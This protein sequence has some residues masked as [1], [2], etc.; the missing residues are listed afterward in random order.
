MKKKFLK[1]NV[2]K[3]NEGLTLIELLLYLS[4]VIIIVL[5][6]SSFFIVVQK[7]KV[8]NEAISTVEDQGKFAMG[9]VSEAIHRAVRVVEP[10]LGDLT[11]SLILSMS[12]P[13]KD[14]T[15]FSVDNDGILNMTEGSNSPIPL[16]DERVLISGAPIF[17]LKFGS[18]GSDDNQ[19]N[20]VNGMAADSS[21][22]LYVSD[23]CNCKI[24]KFS[25][26]GQFISKFGSCGGNDDQFYN[27]SSIAVDSSGY[28]YVADSS[29]YKIKKFDPNGN[30]LFN[31]GSQGNNPGQY[32][33]LYSYGTLSNDSYNNLFVLE[34][35][36]Y[37][38]EKFNSNGN[39]LLTIGSQG[40]REDQFYWPYF[41]TVDPTGNVYVLDESQG[42]IKKFDS[43]GNFITQFGSWANGGNG[44]GQ[45]N[46]PNGLIS[47]GSN[48]YEAEMCNYYIQE[49]NSDGKYVGKFGGQGI[50]DENF[51]SSPYTQAGSSFGNLYFL[52]SSRGNIKKF[53]TSIFSNSSNDYNANSS[54]A[55]GSNAYGDSYGSN[56]YSSNAYV[57][58]NDYG[59]DNYNL[60]N[61]SCN[62]NLSTKT[63]SN[64]PEYNYSKSFSSTRT[65]HVMSGSGK[66][67]L[68]YVAGAGGTI[69][70][71]ISQSLIYGQTGQPVTANPNYGYHFVDWN[72]S[73]TNAARTDSYT[74]NDIVLTARFAKDQH[75]V[76]YSAGSGGTV[77]GASLNQTIRYGENGT[78]VTAMPDAGYHFVNWICNNSSPCSNYTNSITRTDSPTQDLLIRAIFSNN[79][80]LYFNGGYVEAQPGT[81][82]GSFTFV[83]WFKTNDCGDK[84]IVS[85][86][87][88]QEGTFDIQTMYCSRF[89]GDING[90]ADADF[91]QQTGT[92]YQVAYVVS[93]DGYKI[94]ANGNEIGSGGS[95]GSNF[96]FSNSDHHV[97]LGIYIPTDNG[98]R[99]NGNID[100]MEVWDRALLGSEISTLY[101][102][103]SGLYG[104]VNNAP[105][106]NGLVI[107]YHFDEATGTTVHDFSGHGNDGVI[108]GNV[109]WDEGFVSH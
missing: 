14:P 85:T 7:N 96:I 37:R 106:N 43:N 26:K 45:F 20:C 9:V 73:S 107:G 99:L 28:I 51:G 83:T 55:Y 32:Q 54:N 42:K 74:G 27:I 109:T 53:V 69:S 6:I 100:E 38:V 84:E 17:N 18:W 41:L 68:V 11:N 60:S 50:K 46:C 97:Y 105:F 78:P 102:N 93:P 80:S 22:N 91:S 89:H 1:K 77:T 75:N 86:R 21:G 23:N 15:I 94:Y 10:S 103:G 8:K 72:D 56:N 63:D 65:I 36:N 71:K 62:F 90:N 101:N 29:Q 16:T 59:A 79:S 108:N 92:W 104:N 31:V 34:T 49:F 64:R 44:D 87:Y 66:N 47:D 52:D 95:R 88:P 4:L 67:A 12:D 70:G 13:T 2:F 40:G 82:S 24:K 25:S 3:K 19:I 39:Y 35:W 98:Y 33:Y 30:Y 5:T 76:S 81:I 61:V 48:V 57:D 58:S